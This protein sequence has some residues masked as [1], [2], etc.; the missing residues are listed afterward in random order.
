M[1]KLIEYLLQHIG[2]ADTVRL[3]VRG[4]EGLQLT[5]RLL[6]QR[7]PDELCS[8]VLSAAQEVRQHL[9]ENS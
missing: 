1:Q 7:M 5:L 4:Y 9:T 3:P 6:T 8:A 2:E